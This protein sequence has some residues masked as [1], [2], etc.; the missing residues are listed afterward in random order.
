MR[1]AA[2]TRDKTILTESELSEGKVSGGDVVIVSRYWRSQQML[3]LHG[4]CTYTSQKYKSKCLCICVLL[5]YV[6]LRQILC[7]TFFPPPTNRVLSELA[8]CSTSVS[9]CVFFVAG[10]SLETTTP[11]TRLL[12]A[13]EIPC[14]KPLNVVRSDS[15][16]LSS[17]LKLQRQVASVSEGTGVL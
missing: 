8:D 14:R 11:L 13:P 15:L 10:R 4:Y 3:S 5:M 1:F 7:H 6:D 16:N 2:F 9:I 12:V 17:F